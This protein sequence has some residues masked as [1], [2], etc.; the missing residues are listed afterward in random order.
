MDDVIVIKKN[1]QDIETWRYDGQVLQRSAQAV[2]LRAYFNRA[3]LPFHG[4]FFAQGDRFVEIY[5]TQHWYNFFEIYNHKDNS[6]RGWYCNVCKPAEF[7][8]GLVSYV[9]LAL[10]LLVF[11]DGRQLVLDEDEF[12]AL[13]LPVELQKNARQ[14]LAELQTLFQ[15][16]I[17]W[18][19]NN[20]HAG[21]PF[22]LTN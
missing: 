10:D 18:R 2:L 1:T 5:F 8:D 15:P 16:P 12:K 21:L 17:R 7:S 9:D 11:P 14:A 6:L 4:M 3:D 13:D 22:P 20:P 19:L